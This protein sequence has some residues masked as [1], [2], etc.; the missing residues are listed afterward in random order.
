MMQSLKLSGKF[1]KIG[2]LIVGGLSEMTDNKR[3]FGKTPQKIVAE[4][5]EGFNFPVVYNFPAGHIVDNYPIILGAE[6][7]LQ[8]LAESI[9]IKMS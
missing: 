6:T 3:P 8:V 2:G 7:S 1:G 5:V 4:A 9:E